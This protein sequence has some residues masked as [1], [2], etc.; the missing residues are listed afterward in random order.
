VTIDIGASLTITQPDIVTGQPRWKPSRVYIF[1]TAS[2]ETVPVLKEAV[3]KL[4]LGQLTLMI[5]VFV[6]EVT[7]EFT[8]G[9]HVL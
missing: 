3:V 8:V 7:D 9:L 4:T 5:W 6:A 2:D 1:K